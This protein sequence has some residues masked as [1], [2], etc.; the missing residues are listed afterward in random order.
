MVKITSTNLAPAGHIHATTPRPGNNDSFTKPDHVPLKKTGSNK[1]I[2][3]SPLVNTP[4]LTPTVCHPQEKR[5]R[6]RKTAIL[7][8]TEVAKFY[9]DSSLRYSVLNREEKDII[10]RWVR[11]QKMNRSKKRSRESMDTDYSKTPKKYKMTV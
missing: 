11:Q 2:T 10:K 6:N 7:E 5:F 8:C 3:L 9:A 4:K 1:S